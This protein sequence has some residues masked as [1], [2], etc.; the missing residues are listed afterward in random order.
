[1]VSENQIGRDQFRLCTQQMTIAALEFNCVEYIAVPDVRVPLVWSSLIKMSWQ[2]MH[3]SPQYR[4]VFTNFTINW[5]SC[6]IRK[7]SLNHG[8]IIL[9]KSLLPLFDKFFSDMTVIFMKTNITNSLVNLCI[10]TNVGSF[11]KFSEILV[12]YV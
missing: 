3:C 11:G 12:F 9:E 8:S 1:M 5:Y 2:K 7:Y 6:R 10:R 4:V